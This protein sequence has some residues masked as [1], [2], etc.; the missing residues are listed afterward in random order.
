MVATATPSVA[1]DANT[2]EHLLNLLISANSKGSQALLKDPHGAS[3]SSWYLWLPPHFNTS[4]DIRYISRQQVKNKEVIRKWKDW[5]QGSNFCFNEGSIIYDRDVSSFE[6][7]GDKL[8]AI[9]F[10]IVLGPTQPVSFRGNPGFDALA[11]DGM[12]GTGRNPGSVNFKVYVPTSDHRSIVTEEHTVSQ[13]Q[14]VRYAI[15]GSL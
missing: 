14:F 3:H 10:Y 13:D 4:L 12:P 9:D 15:T 8:D 11:D 1:Q 7:W 6:T 2:A 5:A